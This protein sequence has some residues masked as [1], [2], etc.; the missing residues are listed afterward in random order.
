MI[1]SSPCSARQYLNIPNPNGFL[2][3]AHAP[4]AASLLGFEKIGE[5]SRIYPLFPNF[6]NTVSEIS[7]RISV[8]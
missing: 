2:K 3:L 5:I 7:A 4:N 8:E 1:E 6:V